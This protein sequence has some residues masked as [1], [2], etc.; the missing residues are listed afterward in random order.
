MVIVSFNDVFH[1]FIAEIYYFAHK[2]L[3]WRH[4]E[5]D[6]VSNPPVT[7]RFPS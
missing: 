2:T 3:Q 7:G 6:D 1:Y 5:R 4:K